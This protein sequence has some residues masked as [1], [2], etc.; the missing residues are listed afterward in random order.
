MHSGQFIYKTALA[1]QTE[2]PR[3]QGRSTKNR[4]VVPPLHH[5]YKDRSLHEISLTMSDSQTLDFAATGDVSLEF[6]SG[7]WKINDLFGTAIQTK[8]PK[9]EGPCVLFTLVCYF[10]TISLVQSILCYL[11]LNL[12]GQLLSSLYTLS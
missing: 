3:K 9:K 2:T 4:R 7:V 5:H 6:N 12:S 8:I 10:S 11:S 1:Y